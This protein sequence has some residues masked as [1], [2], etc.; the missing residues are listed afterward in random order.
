MKIAYVAYDFPEFCIRHANALAEHCDVLLILPENTTREYAHLIDTRIRFEPFYKPRLRQ[1]VRQ[2][3]SALGLVRGIRR[4]GPDVVHFQNGHMYFNLAMPLIKKFPLVITVH[5]ARQHLGDS[6]SG[7]TPQ[8]IMDFGFRR[9]DQVIVH[10]RSMVQTV[11]EELGFDPSEVHVIPLVALGD[12]NPSVSIR[13]EDE[14]VLFFGRIW[15]YKGL[16]FFI[17]AEPQVTALH[18]N[19]KFVIGG[20]GED[21]ERYRKLMVHPE[22]FEVHN[23]WLTDQ[24]RDEMFASASMVV[25]PYIEASQSGVTPIAYAYQKPVIVTDIGGLPDMVEH[26]RTG[27][28]VP[29]RDVDTLAEAILRLLGDKAARMEM[30]RAGKRKLQ[31]ECAPPVVAAQTIEVYRQAI[32]LR[33][34]RPVAA[35]RDNQ[36]VRAC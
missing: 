22:Q 18:P 32:S 15:E 14:A 1:P 27:L 4:F 16:E 33:G 34:P 29:P 6:E 17:R 7:H 23:A 36:K 9:A 11:V 5:D 31:R 2:V 26:G 13:D 19:V 21:F 20:R 28:L 8:W 24:A 12:S 25:L 10:G 30:G 35:K 3:W